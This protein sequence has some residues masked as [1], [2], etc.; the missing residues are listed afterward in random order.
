M[1]LTQVQELERA[2]SHHDTAFNQA[3]RGDDDSHVS[4]IGCLLLE[5]RS[6]NQAYQRAL[7]SAE[8]DKRVRCVMSY[9]EWIEVNKVFEWNGLHHVI[10]ELPSVPVI[11]PVDPLVAWSET[12]CERT[13]LPPSGWYGAT[14]VDY[15]CELTANQRGLVRGASQRIS[16][17]GNVTRRH[18]FSLRWANGDDMRRLSLFG[19]KDSDCLYAADRYCVTPCLHESRNCMVLEI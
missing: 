18:R 2:L 19:T 3:L 8:T 5:E 16:P 15:H 14:E 12:S 11:H 4:D 7:R 13:R 17:E 10:Q 6:L 9:C 1:P